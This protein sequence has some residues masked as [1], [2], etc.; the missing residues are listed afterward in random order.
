MSVIT[1]FR[2]RSDA[3]ELGRIL[4]VEDPTSIELETLVPLGEA[5]APLFWVY[6][7]TGNAFAE[8]VQ[9]HP[10]VDSV[11]E[12][13]TFEDRTLFMLDW[14]VNEDEVF[15]GLTANG[16]QLLSATGTSSAWEFEVRFPD[17]DDLSEFR[18]HCEDANVTLEIVRVY[19]PTETDVGPWYGL[20]EPQRKAIVLA[21]EEG[22][23]S[24]PRRCS[25]IE[26]AAKLD[27][28]DQAVTE[29][30]RRAIETLVR[31]TL[32]VS[33]ETFDE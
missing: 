25:T 18:N 2:L 31:N 28:S 26:L 33:E 19:N 1:E 21:V 27:I 23:Y 4:S 30:L 8:T 16:G 17:H 12:M 22:Y 3:F 24:L 14:D 6:D 29:R 5:H 11:R 15:R 9:R 7:S 10:S 32:F 13:D 20:T